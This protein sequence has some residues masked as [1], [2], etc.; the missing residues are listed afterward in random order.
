MLSSLLSGDNKTPVLDSGQKSNDDPCEPDAKR[1]RSRSPEDASFAAAQCDT[2]HDRE[3]T[4]SYKSRNTG[5]DI[6]VHSLLSDTSQTPSTSMLQGHESSTTQELD[7]RNS[8]ASTASS[9]TRPAASHQARQRTAVACRYCRKRKIRC[10][11][12]S[13]DPQDPRCANCRRLD[14][15]CIYTPVGAPLQASYARPSHETFSSTTHSDHYSRSQEYRPIYQAQAWQGVPESK[16]MQPQRHSYPFA[17]FT[18]PQNCDTMFRPA[19]N[20]GQQYQYDSAYPPYIHEQQAGPHGSFG[21]LKAET[22]AVFSSPSGHQPSTHTRVSPSTEQSVASKGS[23][24]LDDPR[25]PQGIAQ[26]DASDSRIPPISSL[27]ASIP[28]INLNPRSS[29]DDAML[30]RL[31]NPKEQRA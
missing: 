4:A 6:S 18:S 23:P 8:L 25:T 30:S 22:F 16:T 28:P 21:R 27:T 10:T 17:S 5:T 11:G 3:D 20:R 19:Q 1:R 2:A 13:H 31:L 7:R 15:E 12:M 9:A 14:Q 24:L 26:L 29:H